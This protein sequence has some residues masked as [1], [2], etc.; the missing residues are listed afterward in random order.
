MKRWCISVMSIMRCNAMA[1]WCVCVDSA[2]MR[3]R[4]SD[5]V[6]TM[7][8]WCDMARTMI[9]WC[10]N[11]MTMVR[12]HD[13]AIERQHD[14]AIAMT[15]WCDSDDAMLHRAIISFL[16]RYCH[17]F[18]V[19]VFILYWQNY[20]CARH[21]VAHTCSKSKLTRAPRSWASPREMNYFS[22]EFTI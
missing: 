12:C 5:G 3:W 10:D 20:G 8:R 7:K 11:A 19:A 1:R 15:W 9:R 13:E 17:R 4:W 14:G 18:T 6:I 2:I 21:I 16:S 22:R